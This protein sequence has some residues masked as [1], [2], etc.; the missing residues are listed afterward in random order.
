MT[1]LECKELIQTYKWKSLRELWQGIQEGN[2]PDWEKGKALE[3]FILRAFELERAD[4]RYPY[5]VPLNSISTHNSQKDMEQIDGVVYFQGIGCLLEC[6]D[7]KEAI[8]FEPIAK[9]RSQ[10]MRRPSSVI[11][12]IFSMSGFTEPAL[13]LLNFI[14]PQTIL[15]WQQDEIEHCL[16]HKSFCNSLVKKYHKAVELGTYNFSIINEE[17]LL[18]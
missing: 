15:A 6:K 18:K 11:A 5:S 2:T 3:Y 12:S 8:N 10:L 14:Q 1:E 7:Y 17:E 4:V 9:L 13:M 16:N